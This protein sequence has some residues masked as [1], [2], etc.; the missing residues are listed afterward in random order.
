MSRFPL[1]PLLLSFSTTL[2]NTTLVVVATSARLDKIGAQ[3]L[4]RMAS[5]GMLRALRPAPT[6][7]DGDVV[8]ALST[9]DRLT[10]PNALGSLAADLTAA[11]V[12]DAARSAWAMFGLPASSDLA[13]A[14]GAR[15]GRR[16]RGRR[17]QPS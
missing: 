10:D 15:P 1:L 3:R 8:F 4:A 11:A 9:G 14:H 13:L 5:A 17:A 12:V 7:Y 16:S 6:L 2:Q